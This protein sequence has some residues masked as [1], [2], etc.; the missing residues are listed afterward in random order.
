[1][2]TG[3]MREQ[4]AVELKSNTFENVK[5]N[6]LPIGETCVAFKGIDGN[7]QAYFKTETQQLVSLM[8]VS[9]LK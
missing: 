2:F 6:V 9:K 4:I 5:V 1:M 3:K 8:Q 7:Y